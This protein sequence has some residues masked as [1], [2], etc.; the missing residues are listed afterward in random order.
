MDESS[1]R[2]KG[3]IGGLRGLSVLVW[4]GVGLL[5]LAYGP[6]AFRALTSSSGPEATTVGE[7]N[8]GGADAFRHVSITG[9][10]YYEIAYTESNEGGDVVG[11]YYL[12][13]DPNTGQGLIVQAPT[14][15]LPGGLPTSVTLTGLIQTSP[16]ELSDAIE[17][18]Q[19]FFQQNGV[20]VEPSFYLAEGERPI[21]LL[22]ASGLLLGS[23]LLVVLAVIPFFFPSTVF[24]ARPS[25]SVPVPTTPQPP[26]EG[27]VRVRGRFQQVKNLYPSM[28]MGKR[29]QRFT[30]AVANLSMLDDGR[31]MIFIHNVV[32]TKLYGVV[33]V[34]RQESDWAVF[35]SKNEPWQI[36][37]GTIYSWK[38]RP[39]IRFRREGTGSRPDDIFVVFGSPDGQ[40]EFAKELRASGFPVGSG[41]MG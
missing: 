11:V 35:V 20:V 18:D 14:P 37:P 28:E 23:G 7:L 33:T 38:D 19:P 1:L 17:A 13:L 41:L 40:A 25:T 3:R 6:R 26:G 10:P 31:L 12:F 2:W 39:A 22:A 21:S 16:P 9:D 30:D 36:E 34:S 24:A 8:A 32:R 4:L 29:R 27:G 15:S 5:L